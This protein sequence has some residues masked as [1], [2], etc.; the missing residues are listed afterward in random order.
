VGSDLHE[1]VAVDASHW[2]SENPD[3]VPDVCVEVSHHD[4]VPTVYRIDDDVDAV[5]NFVC[6]VRVIARPGRREGLFSPNFIPKCFTK[7][8]EKVF[9]SKEK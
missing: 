3:G 9:V 8:L 6:P 4:P 5:R 7:R 1:S 2:E